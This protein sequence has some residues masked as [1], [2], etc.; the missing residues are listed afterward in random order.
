MNSETPIRKNSKTFYYQIDYRVCSGGSD[1][2]E[3]EGDDYE[4]VATHFRN[5]IKWVIANNRSTCTRLHEYHPV[6]YAGFGAF[7]LETGEYTITSFYNAGWA[8]DMFWEQVYYDHTVH[9]A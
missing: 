9:R 4:D 5:D 8:P 1:V 7:D 3:Y 6:R 2:R